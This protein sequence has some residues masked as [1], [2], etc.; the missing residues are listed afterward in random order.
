MMMHGGGMHSHFDEEID[1]S[2]LDS[3]RLLRFWK[4]VRPYV[5]HIIL[6]VTLMFVASGA[7]LLGPFLM[8]RA[9]DNY[10]LSKTLAVAERLSGLTRIV[11][12]YILLYGINWL[13]TYWQTYVV[14]WAGQR[15]IFN[16]RKDLFGHLQRLGLKFYDKLEA[17]RIM[18][19]VTNDVEAVNQLLSSGLVSLLNDFFTIIGIM[20]IMLTMNWQLA[21]CAFLT[22]PL[23]YV[24]TNVF[25]R[26]MRKAYHRVRRRIADVNANLQESISGIRVTQSFT[27]EAVN[28][29]RFEGTNQGNMQ[30]N[31][32]AA[33]LTAAFFPLVDFIGQLGTTIVL[34]AGGWFIVTATAGSASAGL[35]IGILV[36]FL[37]YVARFFMPIRDLS[38]LYNLY[39]SAVVSTERIFEFF[40]EVPDVQDAPDAVDLP[41]IVGNVR[42][43][44]IEFGYEENKPV[45][46][47]VSIVAKPGQTIALVGPTGAGK[48]TVIN[49]LTRFYDP[50]AGSV[51]IDGHD[52]RHVTLRSLRRQLGIVLQDTFLFSGTIR[53][54]IRY[55]RPDATDDQVI[56]AARAV[57]AHEFI[58]GLPQG[59]DTEV[60]ERGNKLSVGQRQLIAFA[61]ALLADPAILILDEATSS[62]DA[63]TE[64]LIQRALER[65][66]H[67]RTA[68]VIAHRLSTIRN[69]DRIYVIDFGQVVES[70]THQELL[71]KDGGRYRELYEKQF[72]AETAGISS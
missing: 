4:Y 23:L 51:T 69:A 70:G 54:N 13:C 41:P 52:I 48:S 24:A 16:V 12:F 63:Y 20:V 66:L 58:S 29:N 26:R 8:Q 37:N 30:A 71:A 62:V 38:Q 9:I 21:L 53:D 34:W 2:N 72:A 40:D 50:Q 43:D 35:T 7:G 67:N 25:Q 33:T 55:G 46:R 32:E 44:D 39:Q 28:M 59:Y 64:V 65:L 56:E 19:R 57:N 47:G 42:F 49:L 5:W 14:S 18:S 22:I 6:S 11:L 15:I 10:I 68:F 36:A 1:A 27:R 17:G 3:R 61:R 31:L 60:Q 45:L